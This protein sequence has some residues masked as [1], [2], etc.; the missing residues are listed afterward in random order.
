MP[1][2][3]LCIRLGVGGNGACQ[4]GRLTNVRGRLLS[5]QA[6][7]LFLKL[8]F[9]IGPR[10]LTLDDKYHTRVD[11][12]G[13]RDGPALTDRKQVAVLGHFSNWTRSIFLWRHRPSGGLERRW[14]SSRQEEL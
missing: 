10:S 1:S 13:N 9:N 14:K 12:L 2:P 11:D 4:N 8:S 5:Q 7:Q 3:E 6:E